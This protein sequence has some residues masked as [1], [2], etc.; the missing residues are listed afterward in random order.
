MCSFGYPMPVK[1]R[2]DSESS[3]SA[4]EK[5]DSAFSEGSRGSREPDDHNPT[6]PAMV[7]MELTS[8]SQIL[9]DEKEIKEEYIEM[10]DEIPHNVTYG[11]NDTAIDR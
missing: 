2:R 9:V 7:M 10:E 8:E 5:T 11:S 4:S 6:L 1:E 3:S